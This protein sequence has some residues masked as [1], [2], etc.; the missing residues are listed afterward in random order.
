MASMDASVVTLW[1]SAGRPTTDQDGPHVSYVS[2]HGAPR[3]SSAAACR[4]MRVCNCRCQSKIE[5]GMSM[6]VALVQVDFWGETKPQPQ[7]GRT[8]P[9]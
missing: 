8:L 9:D 1:H 6:L 7:L 3:P 4:S 2:Q 5:I